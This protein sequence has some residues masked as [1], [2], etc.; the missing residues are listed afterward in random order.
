MILGIH[1]RYNSNANGEAVT[2]LATHINV[3]LKAVAG[4]HAVY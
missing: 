3:C 2:I 4:T 1:D